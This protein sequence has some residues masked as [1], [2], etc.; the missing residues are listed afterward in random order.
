M[1]VQMLNSFNQFIIKTFIK[2]IFLF[3]ENNIFILEQP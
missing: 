1:V 2:T 3:F